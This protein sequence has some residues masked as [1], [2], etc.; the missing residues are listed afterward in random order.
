MK[1]SKARLI[2]LYH[3]LPVRS[4]R[5]L[6]DHTTVDRDSNGAPLPG[7][8]ELARARE[9]LACWL[10]QAE[11]E[12]HLR[13]APN[14]LQNEIHREQGFIGT[15]PQCDQNDGVVVLNGERWAVC[16][17]HFTR[18][19]AP[20]FCFDAQAR[21]GFSVVTPD[22]AGVLRYT[23]IENHPAECLAPSL[24]ST[25]RFEIPLALESLWIWFRAIVFTLPVEICRALFRPTTR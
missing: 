17:A 10:K 22:K 12:L 3:T 6:L 1:K 9:V 19:K 15:C 14:S 25:L 7:T 5:T 21:H 24:T 16:H 8:N 2:D 20:D 4:L 23:E 11:D 13:S 18:W